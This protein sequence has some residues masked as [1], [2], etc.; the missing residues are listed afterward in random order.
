MVA[1]VLDAAASGIAP[2]AAAAFLAAG[3]RPAAAAADLIA[4]WLMWRADR[5]SQARADD[6]WAQMLAELNAWTA[7]DRAYQQA[8]HAHLAAH[9]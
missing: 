4:W 3:R 7:P 6:H 1:M 2:L 8:C 9:R 5:A